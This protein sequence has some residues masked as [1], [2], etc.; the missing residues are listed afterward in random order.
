[1]ELD[2]HYGIVIGPEQAERALDSDSFDA[3][4]FERN[5]ERLEG[6]LVSMGLLKR[7]S[8]GCAYVVN[9]FARD[10]GL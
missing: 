10:E 9:P 3:S 7:L 1:M 2:E 5:R 4:S 6:R 8:D